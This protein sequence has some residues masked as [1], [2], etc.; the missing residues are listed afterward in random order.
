MED[1]E[2]SYLSME[3]LPT[4]KNVDSLGYLSFAKEDLPTTLPNSSIDLKNELCE[5]MSEWLIEENDL[6]I[7]KKIGDG[8]HGTVYKATLHEEEIALKILKIVD[9][10]KFKSEVTNLKI[11]A[12]CEFIVPFLGFCMTPQ[13]LLIG[14]RL[15]EQSLSTHLKEATVK[16]SL[17]PILQN[18]IR[19]G[20]GLE[21]LHSNGIIHRDVTSSNILMNEQFQCF[22]GDF[23]LSR[24]IESGATVSK[25]PQKYVPPECFITHHHPTSKY[26]VYQFS[27]T[28]WQML[29]Y[30]ELFPNHEIVFANL[31]P[32]PSTKIPVVIWKILTEGWDEN[33]TFR[34]SCTDIV[35]RVEALCEHIEVEFMKIPDSPVLEQ[36]ATASEYEISVQTMFHLKS[37][38]FTYTA[39]MTDKT[40]A[41]VAKSKNWNTPEEAKRQCL[42]AYRIHKVLSSNPESL[43]GCCLV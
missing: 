14:M 27:L 36:S 17:L 40:G 13:K 1:Q 25:A 21:F 39:T 31:R 23:G 32:P 24:N 4:R 33:P 20:K 35:D 37:I 2:K 9:N 30:E 18:I 29:T 10:K 22:I 41:I 3:D 6:V 12:K 15:M 28:I 5:T 26:D 34:P 43:G 11:C 38:L 7:G 19:I 16:L 8:G 42:E